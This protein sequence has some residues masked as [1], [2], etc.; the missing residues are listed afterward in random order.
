MG[1]VRPVYGVDAFP[2]VLVMTSIGVIVLMNSKGL[3]NCELLHK[4]L[5]TKPK[6]A[7]DDKIAS[8]STKKLFISF[9]KYANS[10]SVR[11]R[12]LLKKPLNI[13]KI[14]KQKTA[15]IIKSKIYDIIIFEAKESIA[16]ILSPFTATE[17]ERIMINGIAKVA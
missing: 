3:E 5:V 13:F 9:I 4:N 17:D 15:K 14:N 1:A 2:C 16:Y 10:L 7:K 12:F 6:N 8:V 11:P